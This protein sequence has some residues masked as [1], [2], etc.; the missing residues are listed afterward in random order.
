[1]T[2]VFQGMRH[3]FTRTK[4]TIHRPDPDDEPSRQCHDSDP[5]YLQ[6]ARTH[7]TTGEAYEAADSRAARRSEHAEQAGSRST[8]QNS[9]LGHSTVTQPELGTCRASWRDSPDSNAVGKIGTRKSTFE[10]Q[11]FH[12]GKECQAQRRFHSPRFTWLSG[13]IVFLCFV[14]TALSAV[15]VVLAIKGQRYGTYI[16]NRYGSKMG[17]ANAIL[18]TS[19]LAKTVELCFV[20]SFVAFLGQVISR[21]ASFRGK[22]Q[23]VSLSEMSMWRWVVQP[24]TLLTQTEIAKFSGLSVLGFLTLFSTVLSMLYVSA[25]TALVQP[26]PK[27]SEW[28]KK[29]MEGSVRLRAGELDEFY[30]LCPSPLNN[31]SLQSGLSDCTQMKTTGRSLYNLATFL[32]EWE[33]TSNF[34]N[35]S[36]SQA[37][38]PAWVGLPYAKSTVTPQWINVK[39]TTEVSK[40]FQR[41]VNNVSLAMPHTGILNAVDD[42][43]NDMPQVDDSGNLEPYRL[44]ASV[45]SPVMNV[46]CVN[47]NEDELSPMVHFNRTDGSANDAASAISRRAA[48]PTTTNT[49]ALDELFGWNRG[50]EEARIGNQPVF[51]SYPEPF[52]MTMNHTIDDWG[53]SGVYLLGRGSSTIGVADGNQGHSL[54]RISVDVSVH[55]STL[56]RVTTFSNSLEARCEEQAEGMAYSDTHGDAVVVHNATN[57]RSLVT[58]WFD[59]MALVS[60]LGGS[61]N[62]HSR[63]L[64]M[65]QL[66]AQDSDTGE[67]DVGLSPSLPSLAEALAVTAG[68]SLLSTFQNRPFVPYWNFTQASYHWQTQQFSA[69]LKAPEYASGGA[70]IAAK[71]WLIVL[72]PVFVL[73]A[74]MLIYFILQPGL[75]TDLSQ[76]PQLF[77]LAINSPP[78]RALAGSCGAGPE[79]TQYKDKWILHQEGGHLYMVPDASEETLLS[80]KDAVHRCSGGQDAEDIGYH[81]NAIS[82]ARASDGF[83]SNMSAALRRLNPIKSRLG[84]NTI[85]SAEP[86]RLRA[87]AGNSISSQSQQEFTGLE[88]QREEQYTRL[89]SGRNVF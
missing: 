27:E 57:Q 23:G 81:H 79:G 5:P 51:S 43:N 70:N 36:I 19:I 66:K 33:R 26:I 88:P 76:P 86:F 64:M 16:G 7:A 89:A 75:V 1:M 52:G 13:T 25:A 49:T 59:A 83:L 11:D 14:S 87:A 3:Q 84:I 35:V 46:L 53:I 56:F 2:D 67:L 61:D 42:P 22:G 21:R 48:N 18:L 29:D 68:Y 71:A 77:A 45:P 44:W 8:S 74:L 28:Q 10:Q 65:L 85:G 9:T 6:S 17:S 40:S 24:G 4:E 58:D 60:R 82:E 15:F 47:L 80:D 78:A 32:D 72:V 63:K 62:P 31:L 41:V 39:N 38:R 50:G 37:E 54:C 12:P 73:S 55:C 69:I 30:G 20:T 34:R